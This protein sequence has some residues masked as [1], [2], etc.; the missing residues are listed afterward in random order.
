MIRD[1]AIEE[2]RQMIESAFE[3]VMCKCVLSD[4]E[5]SLSFCIYDTSGKPLLPVI[6]LNPSQFANRSRL[7][8]ILLEL[9]SE[10]TNFGIAF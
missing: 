8:S 6:N 2:V 3:P 9:R 10:L 7:E 5:N 1:L 4:F